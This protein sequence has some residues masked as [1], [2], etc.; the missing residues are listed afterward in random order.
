MDHRKEP[1]LGEVVGLPGA[2]VRW[3]MLRHGSYRLELFKYYTPE[4]DARP[5]RQCDFGYSHM[6]FEVADVESVF[7]QVT[8]AGYRTVSA[9]KVMRNGRTKVFYAAEPEGAIT[10]FIQ[11]L[12]SD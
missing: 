7:S 8:Q 9:P 12:A 4:G 6:A 10:E 5:R 11:F 2:V 1:A 3:A